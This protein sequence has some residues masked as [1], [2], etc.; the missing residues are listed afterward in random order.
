MYLASQSSTQVYSPF[1]SYVMEQHN[2]ASKIP[3]FEPL[4]LPSKRKDGEA[5][6][7]EQ[8][9]VSLK[10]QNYFAIHSVGPTPTKLQILLNVLM[11]KAKV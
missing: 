8:A 1:G 6:S 9:A 10:L 2:K 4:D 3:V 11:H 5:L 7:N